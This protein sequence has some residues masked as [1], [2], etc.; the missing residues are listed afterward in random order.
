MVV[1]LSII[2]K[3]G[4]ALL[5]GLI[6]GLEREFQQHQRKI[7]DFAGIRTF[8]LLAL[9][10]WLIGF[11]AE[12]QQ[13]LWLVIVATAGITMLTIA[14]YLA[15]H[16]KTKEVGLTSAFSALI[17]FLAGVF[18]AYNQTLLAVIAT[19]LTTTVLSYK[20]YLHTFAQKINL[21]ELHAALKLGIITLIIL[22]LLPNT[23][24]SPTDIPILK[25]L[26]SLFPSVQEVLAATQI[27][28]PFKIWL[29][30]VFI[31]AISTV[32]YVLIRM[33]GTKRGIGLTGAVGGLVSS[34]AVT[35]SL[36]ESSKKSKL[37][38]TFVFGVIIAWSVMFVRVL[39]FELVL[40]K[41][42]FVKSIITLGVM[43]VV[44]LICAIYLYNKRTPQ[45]KKK[46]T[47]VAF[48]SPFALLP[49]LKLGAFVVGILFSA[50]LLQAFF[51]SS[52]IYVASILAGLADVDAITVT[53]ITLA[54]AGE[55]TTDVAV[56]GI[57][58]AVIS[59]TISKAGIAFLFGNKEFGL[60]ILKYTGIILG[61]GLLALLIA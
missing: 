55:T 39:L 40:N 61:I 47:A 13:Q 51:G 32:G 24:Y 8:I 54:S 22:P 45:G 7:I 16:M 6:V 33:L 15:V 28:N 57:T 19:I 56:T 5:L 29:L 37:V 3:L 43:T 41:E 10:G 1:E 60:T 31:C 44:S 2:E 59:N 34:T 11:F 38:Y 4:I 42:I 20:Y 49:A 50:K 35:S 17:V 58:L 26:I 52:G 9:L 46:E 25:D 14:A 30:I 18:V 53:I 23:A 21:E 36:A 27:F 48:K 12:Q